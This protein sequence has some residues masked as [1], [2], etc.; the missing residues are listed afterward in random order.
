MSSSRDLK[1][2]V[3]DAVIDY[4]SNKGV[5]TVNE[6]CKK[7]GISTSCLY[8]AMG[9]QKIPTNRQTVMDQ[10]NLRTVAT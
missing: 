2:N 10:K 6:I 5:K 7:H 1:P 8:N 9:R 4:Y 3:K